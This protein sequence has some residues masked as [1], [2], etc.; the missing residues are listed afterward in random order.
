MHTCNNLLSFAPEIG[1]DLPVLVN[2]R[3]VR[4]GTAE[5]GWT[6]AQSGVTHRSKIIRVSKWLFRAIEFP[7]KWPSP[8]TNG[9]V[10]L[11]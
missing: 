2:D 4:S 5:N 6:F 11:P 1:M 3:E 10:S 9:F 8:D 7:R